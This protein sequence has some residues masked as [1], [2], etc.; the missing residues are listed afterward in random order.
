M[1]KLLFIDHLLGQM[2][3]LKFRIIFY[4]YCK[5]VSIKLLGEIQAQHT[6]VF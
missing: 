3:V 1:R 2:D 6:L 4:K 5:H